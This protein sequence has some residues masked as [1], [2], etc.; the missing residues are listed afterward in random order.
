MHRIEIHQK[1]E[2]NSFVLIFLSR[3]R[4]RLE[5]ARLLKKDTTTLGCAFELFVLTVNEIS[6]SACMEM[7]YMMNIQYK[8]NN[9]RMRLRFEALEVSTSCCRRHHMADEMA[10]CLMSGTVIPRP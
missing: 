5:D 4:S 9:E 3:E 2:F 7:G 1:L 10:S 8:Q 6:S